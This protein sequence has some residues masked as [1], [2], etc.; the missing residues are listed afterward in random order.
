MGKFVC[1]V[2]RNSPKDLQYALKYSNYSGYK[3]LYGIF[4]IEY[5]TVKNARNNMPIYVARI[6]LKGE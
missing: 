3:K 2:L 4:T 6:Y 1:S 5:S